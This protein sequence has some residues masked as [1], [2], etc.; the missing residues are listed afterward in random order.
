MSYI[1]KPSYSLTIG[2]KAILKTWPPSGWGGERT[3]YTKEQE[4]EINAIC[5]R[6]CASTKENEWQWMLE[7]AETTD[8]KHPE[9]HAKRVFINGL[10]KLPDH[11]EDSEAAEF[12]FDVLDM[13]HIWWRQLV[14]NA[15]FK[16]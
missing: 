10:S 16:A 12:F 2:E 11:M 6:V 7:G 8:S 1:K 14:F 9:T 13:S 15:Y 5:S 3:E 4:D